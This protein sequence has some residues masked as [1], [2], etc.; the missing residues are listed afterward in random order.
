M[1]RVTIGIMSA[2]LLWLAGC[3]AMLP[4]LEAPKLDVVSVESN[5]G[6][7]QQ[8]QFRVTLHATNPNDRQITVRSV[9]CE[10]EISGT[11]LAHCA[12]DAQIVL[13]A[14]GAADFG[15]NVSA[16]TDQSLS[17][18]IGALLRHAVDYRIHGRVHLAGLPVGIPFDHSGTVRF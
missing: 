6:N 18:A 8:Q 4:K 7:R 10:L 2:C 17:L 15:V 12:S 14:L 9:E 11:H 1:S 16:E 13:P 3:S 5:G